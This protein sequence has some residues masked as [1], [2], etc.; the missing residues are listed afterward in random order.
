MLNM[1]NVHH[2]QRGINFTPVF[3]TLFAYDHDDIGIVLSSHHIFQLSLQ[4]CI[5]THLSHMSE[6]LKPLQTV[7]LLFFTPSDLTR[8]DDTCNYRG[9]LVKPKGVKNYN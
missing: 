5:M 7:L 3:Y 4:D 8:H 6:L 2:V 9:N 1:L